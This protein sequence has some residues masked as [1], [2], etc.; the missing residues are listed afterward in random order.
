[1]T[2]VHA[3]CIAFSLHKT[4]SFTSLKIFSHSYHHSSA[5]TLY[6]HILNQP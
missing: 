3:Q 1:M 5:S 6:T 4:H 2:V